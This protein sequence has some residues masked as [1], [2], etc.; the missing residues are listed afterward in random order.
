M[1]EDETKLFIS[2]LYILHDALFF[3]MLKRVVS[4][5]ENWENYA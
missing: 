4:V 2:C 1:L 5:F 3:L